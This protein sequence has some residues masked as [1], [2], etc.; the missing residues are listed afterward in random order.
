MSLPGRGM[1]D[2]ALAAPAVAQG[3]TQHTSSPE[4]TSACNA[5]Q[6]ASAP[7]ALAAWVAIASISAGDRQS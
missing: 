3:M 7:E 2:L 4:M 5:D 6:A 1:L